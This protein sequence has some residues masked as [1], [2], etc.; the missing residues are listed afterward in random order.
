MKFIFYVAFY[1]NGKMRL[2]NT[3]RKPFPTFCWSGFYKNG[4]PHKGKLI[5]VKEFKKR[6]TE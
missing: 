3:K 6:V 5:T 2:F 4:K 1:D